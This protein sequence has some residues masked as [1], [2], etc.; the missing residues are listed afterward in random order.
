MMK[1]ISLT[2]ISTILAT[3]LLSCGGSQTIV[4]LGD[5][6]TQEGDRAGGYIDLIR[7]D[8]RKTNDSTWQIFGAGI[9]G[10]KVPDLEARLDRDVLVHSPTVVII[11]I[12]INDVWHYQLGIGGT[13]KERYEEGLRSLCKRIRAAGARTIL[14]TPSVVGEKP[15]GTNPLDPMLDEYAAITRAVAA[16]TGS[17]LCDLRRA[18]LKELKQ[19][20]PANAEKGILTRDGVHLNNAGNR[21]A[22]DQI[23]RILE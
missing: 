20:N 17:A 2:A 3:C 18:F 11:Y 22:A 4:F 14:C 16:E 15:D 21:F 13:P 19:R 12:G 1:I 6:I 9:S 8:L 23:L 7:K 10:N 5:S